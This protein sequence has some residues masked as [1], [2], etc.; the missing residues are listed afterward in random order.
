MNWRSVKLPSL[1]KE[2]SRDSQRAGAAGWFVQENQS[3]DQHHPRAPARWLSRHPSSS[4]QGSFAVPVESFTPSL[5]ADISVPNMFRELGGE[6]PLPNS[7]RVE[8][9]A[10]ANGPRPRGADLLQERSSRKRAP[11]R[12]GSTPSHSG[13]GLRL[14]T[15]VERFLNRRTDAVCGFGLNVLRIQID[16]NQFRNAG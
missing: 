9:F 1:V 5:T 15:S 6:S 3:L 4:E 2:G 12:H 11:G 16:A 13:R 8:R 14:L 10:K 7:D